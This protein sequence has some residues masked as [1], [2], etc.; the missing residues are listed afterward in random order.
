MLGG[1][2]GRSLATIITLY[3]GESTSAMPFWS[4]LGIAPKQWWHGLFHLLL[5]LCLIAAIVY[6]STT[7]FGSYRHVFHSDGALKSVLAEHGA[8][9][10]RM[11]P[12][13]WVYANGDL[14]FLGPLIFSII[15][16]PFIGINY[17]G[18]A[19]AGWA[20]Y[21]Y[22]I[23][24]VYAACRFLAPSSRKAAIAA[25]SLAAGGLSA[26]NFEF[27][28][29]QAAYPI[30]AVFA[31][32]L[33]ALAS[34][35]RADNELSGRV[36][37]VALAF[38]ASAI[39]CSTNPT[40]GVVTM[41]VPLVT[42]WFIGTI[43]SPGSM[44]ERTQ[45]FA[46]P[47]VMAIL[48]GSVAGSLAYY[49]WLLPSVS[50]Y[51]AAARV[52]LASTQQILRHLSLIPISWF[53]Y[54]QI[55]GPWADLGLSMRILQAITWVIA[56]FLLISPI[57][58][59][60][61]PRRH[62]QRLVI[63]SWIVLANFGVSFAALC[64]SAVLFT[65]AIEMRYA[66]FGIYGGI[67]VLAVLAAGWRWR[68]ASLIAVL[69]LCL[70][71]TAVAPSWRHL[72]STPNADLHGI[73]YTDRMNLIRMLGHH[74][75]GVAL[76]SYWNSHV[77]SV[78]SGG[79]VYAYPIGIGTQ[80]FSYPHHAPRLV[81][82]GDNGSRQAIVLS[83]N[84]AV[85]SNAWDAVE[86]Q[87]GQPAAKTQ[88]GP[89]TVWIYDK[90]IA[91]ILFGVG[92]QVDDVIPRDQLDVT[93]SNDKFPRCVDAIPCEARFE[94]R[95]SGTH[96]LATAGSLPLRLGLQGLDGAGKVVVW[97]AG[98]VDFSAPLDPGEST[99]L[100]VVLPNNIAPEVEGFHLCLIQ[101][102]VAW[103]CDRTHD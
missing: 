58:V 59:V 39:F 22:L 32:S 77:L 46:N 37:P 2:N 20:C 25:A 82:T 5:W 26:A 66:T 91:E 89:F 88:S 8:L 86:Y 96:A 68:S 40:R 95:N 16:R 29:G 13:Q 63:F 35:A 53:E 100:R 80:V 49:F 61:T 85:G 57:Y 52:E 67:C 99:E 64:L 21:L 11:I 42:G 97:D 36:A 62:A 7:L 31:L 76:A 44:R 3:F 70:V 1:W 15:L 81:L 28:I 45:L 30:F 48:A 10:G 12:R 51:T 33:F 78:L 92:Y 101:E 34:S 84:D 19:A 103:L 93:L 55:V 60:I 43:L 75:V 90:E 9:E 41:L 69:G 6:V 56:A 47:I 71:G 50:N 74:K 27:V 94:V 23:A 65:G 24:A 83:M 54:F 14:L 38:A 17:F 4:A 72:Y 87:F 73:S 102:G 98:R 79:G 18:N